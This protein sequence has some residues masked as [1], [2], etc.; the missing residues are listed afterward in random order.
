M[1]LHASGIGISGSMAAGA[2][3]QAYTESTT[4]TTT[5]TSRIS[6]K[7][8]RGS[9]AGV[10]TMEEGFNETPNETRRIKRTS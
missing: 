1:H 8:H 4:T 2:R 6:H 10:K 3:S 5:T 9:R 7:A